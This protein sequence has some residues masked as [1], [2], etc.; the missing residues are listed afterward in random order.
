MKTLNADDVAKNL[1]IF[2]FDWEEEYQCQN[3]GEKAALLNN[4]DEQID[5]S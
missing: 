5:N 3:I 1:S 4:A 2:S